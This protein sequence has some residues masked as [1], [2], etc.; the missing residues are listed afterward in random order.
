MSGAGTAILV[1][2]ERLGRWLDD[3]GLAP[4]A[5]LQVEPLAGGAS[6]AMFVV[7]R[8]PYEWVL[9]RPAK[10]AIAR[11]DEGMQRE[12]RMLAALAGTEVP[13]PR[14]TALCDDPDVLGRA[15]YLMA[16]VDGFNPMP[17]AL[18]HVFANPARR[19]DIT[20][21]MVDALADLH[22]VDWR[23]AGLGDLDRTEGF[24]DRQVARW[25][26]QL[27]SYGG[28]ELPGTDR[29]GSWLDAHRP[30]AI[31]GA[32]MHGDY[33]MMNVLIAPALPVR[34]AAI[35]DWETATIGDPLLDLA[36]FC[37]I[38]TPNT[39][40]V[41]GWPD[42]ASIVDRYAARRGTS[43]PDLGYHSVLYNFRMT[44]LLEGIYQRSLHDDTRPAMNAVG[45]Q[46]LRFLSRATE[47]VDLGPGS[48]T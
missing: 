45:E 48:W 4:G 35:L 34:V 19:A 21:A 16:R 7:R 10:V 18:P 11:A 41:D 13:H 31:D 2:P 9:R 17:N 32:I 5:P 29:I 42:R 33:H 6:N 22:E 15:F 27:E 44:V 1:D 43:V 39:P 12:Y 36:G 25:T 3:R 40:P 46:A 37:E 14:V 24:H 23:G 8:G 26:S 30:T 47:L 28:R 20:D 38:W